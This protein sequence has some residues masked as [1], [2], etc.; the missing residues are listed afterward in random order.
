[1]E[2]DGIPFSRLLYGI[3][4]FAVLFGTWSLFR[5]VAGVFWGGFRTPLNVGD[6]ISDPPVLFM[7]PLYLL[8]F[9]AI[10]GA[11]FNPAQIWGD[12]LPGGVEASDSLAHFLGSSLVATSSSNSGAAL[13]VEIRWQLVGFVLLASL[14]GFSIPYLFYA[15]FP[16]RRK[17]I[18]RRLA[19]VQA[20]FS[21]REV[22]ALLDRVVAT[23]LV[24]MS[25]A[26]LERGVERGLVDR[27]IV[28]GV[29]NSLARLATYGLRILQ[30]GLVQ[31][32]FAV[33][34]FGALMLLL[35]I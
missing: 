16:R 28:K 34:I 30:P 25:R 24:S 3:C 20:L 17:K 19:P 29:S 32:Y 8:A 21:G 11:V 10:L 31:V 12:L 13:A 26:G 35:V 15:R 18:V 7:A 27:V 9:A 22:G 6:D 33:M 5:L 1:M 23:P 4:V 14:I 2:A